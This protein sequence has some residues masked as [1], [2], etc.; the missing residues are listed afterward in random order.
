MVQGVNMDFRYMALGSG[1]YTA[2]AIFIEIA[3][4]GTY[5][6]FGMFLLLAL[7]FPPKTT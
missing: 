1:V 5:I 6:V 3:N 4:R 7:L 2:F